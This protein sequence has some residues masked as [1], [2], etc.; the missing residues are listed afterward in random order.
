MFQWEVKA[1]EPYGCVSVGGVGPRGICLCVSVEGE[2]L[3]ALSVYF[4]GK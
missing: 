4:S 2:G 1:L 3:R